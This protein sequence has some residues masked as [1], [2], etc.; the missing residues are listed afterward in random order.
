MKILSILSLTVGTTTLFTSVHAQHHLPAAATSNI[1]GG[2]NSPTS[3]NVDIESVATIIDEANDTERKLHDVLT[4]VKDIMEEEFGLTTTDGDGS[5]RRLS[6]S[7]KSDKGI[8]I[9]DKVF[10]LIVL[11]LVEFLGLGGG[12]YDTS[13][14]DGLLGG[15]DTADEITVAHH[16][17]D[18]SSS[19]TAKSEGTD[20]S[21]KASKESKS[22][23]IVF[24]FCFLLLT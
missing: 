14:L 11:L 23:S 22:V 10:L 13:M 9:I 6:K 7:H 20:G 17:H 4:S 21:A 24:R 12:G 19:K 16:G 15:E 18:G 5:G 1:N 2:I 3:S 8:D